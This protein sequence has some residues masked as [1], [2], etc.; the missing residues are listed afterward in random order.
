MTQEAFYN[1]VRANTLEV[2]FSS[3]SRL[4]DSPRHFA[5][6]FTAERKQTDSMILGDAIHTGLLQPEKFLQK[7]AVQPK[8]ANNSS[9]A[10]KARLAAFVAELGY[11]TPIS[12]T[13]FATCE[14]IVSTMLRNKGF[15]DLLVGEKEHRFSTTIDGVPVCGVCDVQ[16][17]FGVVDLKYTQTAKPKKF[18]R[19]AIYDFRYDLQGAI[20]TI[21]NPRPFFILAVDD[22]CYW[23]TFSFDASRI[24]QATKTL[25]EL[26]NTYKKLQAALR[27]GVDMFDKGY[28]YYLPNGYYTI[29]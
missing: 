22:E 8:N 6:Y 11:R 26:L 18:E 21:A 14:K 2:S 16:N 23:I 27:D 13:D 4:M 28:E 25:I 1:A 29:Y 10:N 3:L 9:K 15:T 5:E 17:D 19:K 20:Y 12:E 24:E 7:F